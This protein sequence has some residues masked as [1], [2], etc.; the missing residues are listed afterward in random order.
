MT[1]N[2]DEVV[3]RREFLRRLGRYALG[4]LLGVGIGSL[5]KRPGD[6]CSVAE[7]CQSCSQFGQCQHPEAS[8]ASSTQASRGRVTP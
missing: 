6:R 1:L 7:A 2:V 8:A 5:V 3:S 4:G